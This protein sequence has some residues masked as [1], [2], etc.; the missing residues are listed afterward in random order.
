MFGHPNQPTIQ[1]QPDGQ[2]RTNVGSHAWLHQSVGLVIRADSPSRQAIPE[3]S[4]RD[5]TSPLAALWHPRVVH[6]S[7]SQS[8]AADSL[9]GYSSICQS[10][11][12]GNQLATLAMPGSQSQ[13]CCKSSQLCQDGLQ[14]TDKASHVAKHPSCAKMGCK[15]LTDCLSNARTVE[16]VGERL[17]HGWWFIQPWEITS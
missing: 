4:R 14:M 16:P 7:L 6:C 17:S 15:W 5:N 13:S 1:S 2:A 8:N 12:P 11:Q 9:A 3:G 10:S